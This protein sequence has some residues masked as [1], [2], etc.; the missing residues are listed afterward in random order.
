M[1]DGHW[2]AIQGLL[3]IVWLGLSEEYVANGLRRATY[4]R[5]NFQSAN[6]RLSRVPICM[7]IIVA[8]FLVS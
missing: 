1:G 3:P 7:Q 8:V 5:S 6:T 2:P 4:C